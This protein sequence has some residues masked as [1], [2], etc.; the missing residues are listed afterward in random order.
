MR[1]AGERADV[2]FLLGWDNLHLLDS[3]SH[4]LRH[5]QVKRGMVEEDHFISC[6]IK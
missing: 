1:E 2:M 4:F 6:T 5:E 3:R